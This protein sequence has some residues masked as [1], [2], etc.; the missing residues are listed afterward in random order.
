VRSKQGEVFFFVNAEGHFNGSLD[1]RR[2]AEES[3]ELNSLFLIPLSLILDGRKTA[4][5]QTKNVLKKTSRVVATC[6]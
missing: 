1:F 4:P 5:G 3:L 6:G 2:Q